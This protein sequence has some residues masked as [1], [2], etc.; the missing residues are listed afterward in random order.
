MYTGER[1]KIYMWDKGIV[2][3]L[4]LRRYPEVRYLCNGDTLYLPARQ[5]QS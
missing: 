2:D 5:T 4:F 1:N 3:V